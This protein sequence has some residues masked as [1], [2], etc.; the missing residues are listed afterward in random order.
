M[1]EGSD[2]YQFKDFRHMQ[3]EPKI[4]QMNKIKERSKI[5]RKR[6]AKS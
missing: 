6:N 2:T 5:L 4:D 1:D 3:E